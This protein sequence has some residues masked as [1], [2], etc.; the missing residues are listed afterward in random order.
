MIIDLLEKT[1]DTL[2]GGLAATALWFGFN[3]TVLAERAMNDVVRNSVIPSCIAQLQ[4]SENASPINSIPDLSLP[5]TPENRLFNM[6]IGGMTNK[7]KAGARL[8]GAQ[9]S[10]RCFCAAEQTTRSLK[11]DYAVHTASFRL[12]EAESLSGMRSRSMKLVRSQACGV[13]PWLSVGG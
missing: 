3:Y 9:R 1:P 2:L 4:Q 5:N 8:S 12:I 7:I 13:L 11:F 10:A 6:L